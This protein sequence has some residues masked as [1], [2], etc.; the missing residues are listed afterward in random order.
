LGDVGNFRAFPP[1]RVKPQQIAMKRTDVPVG[2]LKD[3]Q[4]IPGIG[5]SLARDLFDLGIKQVS[6]LRGRNP[7]KLYERLCSLRGTRQD[8]CVLYAF[9]CAVYFATEPKPK[10][11]RLKWWNWKDAD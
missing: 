3:L 5:P 9:R 7:E 2:M 4:R 11:E 1:L 10:P 8:R 6:S